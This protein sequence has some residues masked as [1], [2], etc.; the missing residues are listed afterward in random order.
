MVVRP[1][2]PYNASTFSSSPTETLYPLNNNSPFFP[3]PRAWQSLFYFCLHE[4]V[5][6]LG[7]SSKCNHTILSFCDWLI[8]LSIMPATVIHVITCVK[9]SL[10]K[11]E[12]YPTVFI[13]HTLFIYSG[14][15]ALGLFLSFGYCE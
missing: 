7:T 4:F 6:I 5:S 10:L 1:S 12:Y 3:S 2:P 11:A 13:N 15:R 9:I 8:S 14:S